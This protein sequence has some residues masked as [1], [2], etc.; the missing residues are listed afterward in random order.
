MSEVFAP[1]HQ[2]QNQAPSHDTI[3]KILDENTQIITM[4][5][6][7]FNKGR[8]QETVEYESIHRIWAL[9]IKILFLDIKRYCIEIYIILHVLLIQQIK[10]NTG[11]QLV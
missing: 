10:Y 4:I 5:Q 6:D 7:Y 8:M 9:T 3:Q 1:A 11:Y 2:R